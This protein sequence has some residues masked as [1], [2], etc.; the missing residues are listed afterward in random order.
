MTGTDGACTS[1]CSCAQ[2]VHDPRLVV[3]TGGPGA[4][5]TAVLEMARRSLCRH[6]LVLPEA[7]G[8][9][10][11]GGF[12]RGSTKAARR[13]AQRAIF[14]IQRELEQ[15]HLDE[16]R[17]AVILCDRG[18]LDGIAY[19]P[20]ASDQFF[21]ELGV[22]QADE[23]DRYQAVIHLRTPGVNEGY[24]HSNPLRIEG[25]AQAQQIDHRIEAAWREHPRRTI[26]DSTLDFP[27]KAGR[28]LAAIAEQ[29]PACCDPARA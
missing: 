2:E 19:W 28:A 24:D 20:G 14:H 9:V 11:S 25:A 5:K 7:A 26:I 6:V 29:L 4:G 18:T 22:A 27:T 21:A 3:V 10:F 8:I 15:L 16:H 17:S 13:A 23:L 1:T 12:P